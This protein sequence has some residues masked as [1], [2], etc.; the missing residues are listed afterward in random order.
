MQEKDSLNQL[1]N[2][3]EDRDIKVENDVPFLQKQRNED[4]E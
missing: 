3:I 2:K 1:E 4:R